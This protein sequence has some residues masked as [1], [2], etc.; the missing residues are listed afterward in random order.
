[1]RNSFWSLQDLLE[2]WVSLQEQNSSILV[3]GLSVDSRSIQAGDLFFALKGLEQ[4]GL[5][6]SSQATKRGAVAI[7]WESDEEINTPDLPETIPCIEL[8]D[9]HSKLGLISQRF[10]GDVSQHMYVVGVTG[11]DGKTSITQF[12]AQALQHLNVPCGVIGTLGYGIYPSYRAASHTTPD[13]I[14]VHGLLYEYYSDDVTH[15][16]IEASSH[17]LVQGRL[18]GVGFDTAVFTNLGRDHMDYHASVKEYGKAK[19]LLFQNEN[20]Q[21]AVINIDDAFGKKLANE[22]SE[23]LNVISYSTSSDAEQLN[24]YIK[25]KNIEYSMGETHFDIESSWGSAHINTKLIGSFNVSNLLAVLGS[26]LAHDIEFNR[27]VDAIK[28]VKTVSGRMEFIDNAQ[29]TKQNA[30]AVVIDY[31]HTPQALENVLKVLRAQCIGKLHCVFGCGGDR[32]QGKRKLM[33][34]VVECF[35]NKAILTDDNP[36]FEDPAAI[37]SQ[38]EK[39]FSASYSYELIHDRQSAIKYAIENANSQDIVLIAGK[40]HE[41]I[42]I[43]RDKKVPFDDKKIAEEILRSI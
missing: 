11:T 12:I 15:A 40:G 4:H 5:K 37:T 21:H 26:L 9:L 1:M 16:V 13:A 18:N 39:G 34:Q 20:L 27:A 22:F 35:A 25:A 6:Y 42:Q 29:S 7:A 2:G 30:P 19:K 38:V 28:N 14:Q 24:A 3:R 10:Y 36:R 41:A 8:P 43:I 31:A 23:K 17:G 33:G 32:D